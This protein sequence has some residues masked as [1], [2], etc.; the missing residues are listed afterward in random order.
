[1]PNGHAATKDEMTAN[2]NH[3]SMATDKDSGVKG[4]HG[5]QQMRQTNKK[6]VVRQARSNYQMGQTNEDVVKGQP[7][8]VPTKSRCDDTA[9][10]KCTSKMRNGSTIMNKNGGKSKQHQLGD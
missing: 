3:G 1:M 6:N 2:T 4:W 9:I 7:T 10:K 8:I 5:K